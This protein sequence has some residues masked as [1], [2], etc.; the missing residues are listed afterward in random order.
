MLTCYAECEKQVAS[1]EYLTWSDN[2]VREE[3]WKTMKALAEVN[4]RKS[5]VLSNTSYQLELRES[6]HHTQSV[7]KSREQRLLFELFRKTIAREIMDIHALQMEMHKSHRFALGN[8]TSQLVE[9]TRAVKNYTDQNLG[10]VNSE[11]TKLSAKQEEDSQE[12]LVLLA[13]KVA[14]LKEKMKELHDQ[15]SARYDTVMSYSKG[16]QAAMRNGDSELDAAL[17]KVKTSLA[18][19]DRKESED[20]N[21]T[22]ATTEALN[23]KI[24]EDHEAVLKKT[25]DDSSHLHNDL[26][27]TLDEERRSVNA[28]FAAKK[29]QIEQ[30]LSNANRNITTEGEQGNSALSHM[31]SEQ[32]QNNEYRASFTQSLRKKFEITKSKTF[33]DLDHDFGR[34]DQLFSSL[35]ETETRMKQ[36]AKDDRAFIL[37]V[38]KANRSSFESKNQMFL[39]WLQQSYE[40]LNS[41][42][43]NVRSKLSA[44]KDARQAAESNDVSTLSN[45][46][47]RLI[48]NVNESLTRRA[49]SYVSDLRG[50]IQSEASQQEQRLRE[51]NDSL[52]AD[53]VT[54][55]NKFRDFV[56]QELKVN[57]E[58]EDAI[59]G[60]EQSSSA[61]FADADQGYRGI[62]ENISSTS[63]KLSD[64]ADQFARQMKTDSDNFE[65]QKLRDI[66]AMDSKFEGKIKDEKSKLLSDVQTKIESLQNGRLALQ[67]ES[68]ATQSSLRDQLG[69][70]SSREMLNNKQTAKDLQ[71]LETEQQTTIKG[72]DEKVNLLLQAVMDSESK[73]RS[74]S[75]RVQSMQS[76]ML[77]TLKEQIATSG[78]QSEA[79]LKEKVGSVH[80]I[81]HAAIQDSFQTMEDLLSSQRVNIANTYDSLFSAM[82]S[83]VQTQND[84]NLHLSHFLDRVV[85]KNEADR[86]VSFF[87]VLLRSRSRLTRMTFRMPRRTLTN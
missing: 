68:A 74:E 3:L 15:H 80:F 19:I 84:H 52:I 82:R 70:L 23:K 46:I 59:E 30:A 48:Q 38:M 50:S 32:M 86:H 39:Q 43:D 85:E 2:Q 57:S 53:D 73:F 51:V 16:V 33:H 41:T 81:L 6:S 45:M 44:M 72:L 87:L 67:S 49:D 28:L 62:D 13:Q 24:R 8:L 64:F 61:L 77:S 12:A 7:K 60:L 20:Y 79:S 5:V 55:N 11:V 37:S 29:S 54:F 66:D 76:S 22:L 69:F 42:I 26:L 71:D 35:A 21:N 78:N 31:I 34:I 47:L 27:N 25:L 9:V 17:L 65:D 10:L 1:G 4:A 56:S 18:E 75:Q 14:H 63:S 58:Q 83:Q 40:G 36:Q